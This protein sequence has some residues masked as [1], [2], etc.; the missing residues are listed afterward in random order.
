MGANRCAPRRVRMYLDPRRLCG[1]RASRSGAVLAT[2]FYEARAGALPLRFVHSRRWR[3][4][5][6]PFLGRL[7]AT[8]AGPRKTSA[9]KSVRASLRCSPRL[10]RRPAPEHSRRRLERARLPLTS[11]GRCEK[12]QERHST[13]SSNAGNVGKE[14]SVVHPSPT[15]APAY[16]QHQPH[17]PGGTR[18][19]RSAGPSRPRPVR[20]GPGRAGTANAAPEEIKKKIADAERTTV[21]IEEGTRRFPRH[22]STKMAGER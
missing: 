20:G 16:R 2:R 22:R 18:T 14:Q 7:A 15:R 9:W 21:S 12:P 4:C 10:P 13:T 1:E 5:T 3:V 8:L 19:S 11:Q 6:V 17:V